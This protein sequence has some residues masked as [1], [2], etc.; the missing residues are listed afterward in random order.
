[1]AAP[2]HRTR[3]V[4]APRSPLSSDRGSGAELAGSRG[5]LRSS[6]ARRAGHARAEAGFLAPALAV[7]AVALGVRLLHVVEMGPTPLF[8]V[9]T[10]DSRGYDQWARRLAAGDWIGSEVFY[11]APLYPYFLGIVYSS[12]G[13]DPWVVRLLQAAIGAGSCAALAYAGCRLFSRQAG[14]GAGLILAVYPPAIFYDALIQKSV[15]DLFFTCVAL[16]LIGTIAAGTAHKRALWCLLGATIGALSLTRENAL[17]LAAVLLLWA[18]ARRWTSAAALFMVGLTLVLAP[19]AVR[20]AVVGGGLYLTTSQFGSNFFIGNNP[21][22]DGTYMALREGRGAPEFERRDA[23]ELAERAAGRRLTPSEVSAYWFRRSLDYIRSDTADWL[24]LIA[25]KTALLVN[26]DEMLDT[27]SLESHAEHSTVLALTARV[28]HFGVLLPLAVFGGIVAWQRRAE[29]WVVL[30]LLA[31]YA[32]SVVLFF[33]M[34]RYRHPLAPFLIL[35]AAAGVQGAPA[36]FR[37][38]TRPRLSAAIVLALGAALVS[39]RQ[40]LSPPLMRAITEHNVATA[41]QEEG[42]LDEAIAGYRRALAI[43]PDYAPAFNN[44]GTALV[45]KDDLAGAVRAFRE[46]LRLQPHSA[47]AQTLLADALYDLGSALVVQ[48]AFGDAEAALREA[49]ALK[50]G[51][52]EAHNNLGIALASAGR[53][54]EA[55]AEWE[56]ALAIRPGFTDAERN[57]ARAREVGAKR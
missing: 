3:P 5:A 42:R 52:A 19:V 30:A 55:I 2:T 10:G 56:R 33:V 37:T 15:L 17:L 16:A 12:V 47:S 13:A 22:S 9:L 38:A 50:P 18:G 21:A 1:M 14:I 39:N 28:L 44:L 20:N 45:A 36:F 46:S 11:Q 29:L 49:L 48:G 57:L 25:R 54:D 51:V 41:F 43:Q 32:V 4:T 26:A 23:T 35:F 27:E 6:S 53:L 31:V 7:F 24:A 8:T 40:M 34:G